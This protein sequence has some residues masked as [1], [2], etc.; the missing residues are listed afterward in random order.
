M[1]RRGASFTTK[2]RDRE[3]REIDVQNT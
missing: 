1:K 2:D 3:I